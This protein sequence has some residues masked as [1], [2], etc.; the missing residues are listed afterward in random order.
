MF[1]ERY[2]F[3]KEIQMNLSNSLF[4][5]FKYDTGRLSTHGFTDTLEKL[6]FIKTRKTFTSTAPKL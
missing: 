3:E 6:I 1:T 5:W 2:K 4:E